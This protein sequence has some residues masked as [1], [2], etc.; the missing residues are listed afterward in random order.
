MSWQTLGVRVNCRFNEVSSWWRHNHILENAWRL[1]SWQ[2]QFHL[3]LVRM[4]CKKR[5][6]YLNTVQ[7]YTMALSCVMTSSVIFLKSYMSKSIC[8]ETM[9]KLS[10]TLALEYCVNYFLTIDGLYNGANCKF[11]SSGC[12]DMFLLMLNFDFW[13]GQEVKVKLGSPFCKYILTIND[14][15][16]GAKNVNLPLAVV[17]IWFCEILNFDFRFGQEVKVKLG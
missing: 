1:L 15:Y 16:N 6:V 9:L 10:N 14:V 5:T 11:I 3:H 12:W 2:Y 7:E 17:E 13:F 8:T 4:C